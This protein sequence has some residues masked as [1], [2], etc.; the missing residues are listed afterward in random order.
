M[1]AEDGLRKLRH[2]EQ[3]TGIWTMRC[4][5]AVERK[6]LVIIDKGNGVGAIS[7][8]PTGDRNITN[9]VLNDIL[10][11]GECCKT[12]LMMSEELRN[13]QQYL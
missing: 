13:E 7:I 1:H 2:M 12:V 11:P 3:T 9:Y 5:L 8:S 4:S 10:S 6:Y